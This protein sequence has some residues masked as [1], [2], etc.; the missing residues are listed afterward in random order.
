MANELETVMDSLPDNRSVAAA[1]LFAV[2]FSDA[3]LY[4]KCILFLTRV[5]KKSH[6]FLGNCQL[7]S[8]SGIG[9]VLPSP[10]EGI[11]LGSARG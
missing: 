5:K 8:E 6:F 11:R 4:L 3:R 1:C 2:A 7:S 9:P 10:P